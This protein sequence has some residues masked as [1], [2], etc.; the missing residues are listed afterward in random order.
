MTVTIALV[1]GVVGGVLL[2]VAHY[3]RNQASRM[4]DRGVAGR[5]ALRAEVLDT[6]AR[7]G[8][9]AS[10]KVYRERTGAGLLEAH[11]AV[12]RFVHDGSGE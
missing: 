3:L 5:A 11:H 4:T 9:V 12:S 1:I 6:L 8:W 10:V 2:I 7:A